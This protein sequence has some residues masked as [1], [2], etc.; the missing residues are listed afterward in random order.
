MARDGGNGGLLVEWCSF[1]LLFLLL[2]PQLSFK[3]DET[4][5]SCW[6]RLTQGRGSAVRAEAALVNNDASAEGIQL[7][8]QI[9]KGSKG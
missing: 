2:H 3:D 9:H 4:A 5:A 6:R 1:P 7:G 8:G